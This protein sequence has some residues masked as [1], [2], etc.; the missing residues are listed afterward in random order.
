MSAAAAVALY[1]LLLAALIALTAPTSGVAASNPRCSAS[2][3]RLDKVGENDFTSH[4]G[5]AFA[6]RNVGPVTCTLKGYPRARLLGAQA[7][8]MTTSVV[9]FGGPTKNV[10]L[11]PWHR[12]FFAVT[13]AVS[14]PC[15]SAVFA[16]G[17]RL[18]PPGSSS[19]LVW[20]EGKFDLCGPAP[21]RL[22]VSPVAFPRQF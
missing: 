7:Q 3:L 17:M 9:H 11:H 12:A 6:F 2:R 15:P 1:G 13:F 10:V 5:L 16:Y 21:A 4:R 22:S 8:G 19:G 20:F 18:A 14:G